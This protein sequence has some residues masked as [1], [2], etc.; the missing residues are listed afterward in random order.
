MEQSGVHLRIPNQA[1]VKGGF[2]RGKIM[3]HG[4]GTE[5][6]ETA[7]LY[8]PPPTPASSQ[9]PTFPALATAPLAADI[10]SDAMLASGTAQL[11]LP[12]P[13]TT[14]TRSLR[15][16]SAPIVSHTVDTATT[17]CSLIL[18]PKDDNVV[19]QLYTTIRL[20]RPENNG[21][22]LCRSV[23]EIVSKLSSRLPAK[24]LDAYNDIV[25]Y[26]SDHSTRQKALKPK[27]TI[28]QMKFFSESSKSKTTCAWDRKLLPLRLSMLFGQ[29]AR[30][31]R[32][33][34]FL[35]E[36]STSNLCSL[37]EFWRLVV[38]R[39]GGSTIDW[40]PREFAEGLASLKE[41]KQRQQDLDH[42]DED[43]H[44]DREEREGGSD[45]DNSLGPPLEQGRQGQ[46]ADH[47]DEEDHSEGEEREGGSESDI[48]LGQFIEQDEEDH[49]DGEERE[50]GSESDISVVPS[51]EQGRGGQDAIMADQ[52]DF[53]DDEVGSLSSEYRAL[54][55]IAERTEST[56][57]S[58]AFRI[59]SPSWHGSELAYGTPEASSGDTTATGCQWDCLLQLTQTTHA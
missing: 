57:K 36:L 35:K 15:F 24:V 45:R 21:E 12:P 53:V 48:S 31:S 58:P 13:S 44:R 18:D 39:R 7:K 46:D 10:V 22:N 17:A 27:N 20:L 29:K 37:D 2:H 55:G 38:R 40:K 23:D 28:A 52:H 54:S 33:L 16:Q 14:S 47:T 34:E 59:Q 43:D 26:G 49:R 56:G 42:K 51:I 32:S 25:I 11:G 5:F 4:L 19:D 50:G 30:S 8:G 41:K 3:E 6:H 1:S 9:L